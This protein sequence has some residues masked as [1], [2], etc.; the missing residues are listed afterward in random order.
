M[1]RTYA[2]SCFQ[3]IFRL[4]NILSIGGFCFGL[5][6]FWGFFVSFGEVFV[7]F[8]W[9]FFPLKIKEAIRGANT[10]TAI[11]TMIAMEQ[12]QN[13]LLHWLMK[14]AWC[15]KSIQTTLGKLLYP[16]IFGFLTLRFFTLQSNFK[17]PWFKTIKHKLKAVQ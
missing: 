11:T 4:L 13:N 2:E 9:V 8:G 3:Q 17:V 10:S 7:C 15:I 16:G 1:L 14:P 5:F 6:L 12:T